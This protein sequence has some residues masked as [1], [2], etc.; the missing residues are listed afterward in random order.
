MLSGLCT[1]GAAMC[2]KVDG[3]AI[4]AM[5]RV[6]MFIMANGG[7]SAKEVFD[8]GSQA[9]SDGGSLSGLSTAVDDIGGGSYNV[10]YKI[11]IYVFALTFIFS[12]AGLALA[13]AS[14]RKEK[15][16]K[17]IH[18]VIGVAIAGSAIALIVAVTTL[19]GNIWTSDSMNALTTES[20]MMLIRR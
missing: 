15:K 14:E 1:M 4:A 19:A 7:I 2:Q 3:L 16:D 18:A 8:S 6:S 13:N 10:G 5:N 9:M 17:L 12:A 20:G 11:A